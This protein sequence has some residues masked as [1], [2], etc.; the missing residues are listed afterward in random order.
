MI[1]DDP[2]QIN[3]YDLNGPA[4]L[5]FANAVWRARWL[6]GWPC[7]AVVHGLWLDSRV[8]R[9]ALPGYGILTHAH[10]RRLIVLAQAANLL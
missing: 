6:A 2:D 1:T 7:P 10:V 3:L 4:A 8:V 5:A 9:L